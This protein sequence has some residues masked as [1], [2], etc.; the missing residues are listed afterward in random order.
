MELP[1]KKYRI[2]DIFY[3]GINDKYFQLR[4]YPTNMMYLKKAVSRDINEIRS[5]LSEYRDIIGNVDIVYD[6]K[7]KKLSYEYYD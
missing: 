5:F 7:R 6:R 4:S 3:M 2:L 1:E